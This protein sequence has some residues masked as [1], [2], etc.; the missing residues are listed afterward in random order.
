MDLVSIIIP[1][2]KTEKYLEECMDSVLKQTWPAL[3]II[4]VDDGSPDNAP[5]MCDKYTMQYPNVKVIHQKNSGLGLSRNAG[6]SKAEGA[7][8]LFLDSDD[9]LDGPE[10]VSRLVLCAREKHADIVTG[11]FRRFHNTEISAVNVLHL[12]DRKSVV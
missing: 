6:L 9:C 3:E 11:G 2:Y 4:L 12:R 7:Y 10:T 8:I 1:V 5:A